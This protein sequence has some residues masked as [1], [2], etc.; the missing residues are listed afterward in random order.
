M[1]SVGSNL[2]RL[3]S[4]TFSVTFRWSDGTEYIGCW[5][6]GS[7]N[8]RGSSPGFF[9]LRRPVSHFYAEWA[10]LGESLALLPE[11]MS[12]LKYCSLCSTE[13]RSSTPPAYHLHSVRSLRAVRARSMCARW[14]IAV[15]PTIRSVN[16]HA[17]THTRVHRPTCV[18]VWVG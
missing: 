7:M 1:I 10:P 3:I 16:V 18:C 4:P 6:N 9:R 5:C 2:F 8:G 11:A 14:S 15:G 13:I 12:A 17:H